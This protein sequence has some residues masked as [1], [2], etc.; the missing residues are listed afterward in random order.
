M[1]RILPANAIACV[2]DLRD[3]GYLDKRFCV[4]L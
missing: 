2:I 3:D 4:R 1:G